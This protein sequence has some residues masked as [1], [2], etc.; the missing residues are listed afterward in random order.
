MTHKE[1]SSK[2]GS[3]KSQKK[4]ES[5]RANIAKARL[6]RISHGNM[7]STARTA[8]SGQ[9]GEATGLTDSAG[10]NAIKSSK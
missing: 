7:R 4:S 10:T 6:A 1:F 3:S 2:G 8:A 9:Q 5:S